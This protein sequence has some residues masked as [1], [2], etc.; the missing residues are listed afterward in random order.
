MTRRKTDL[1]SL[2][3]HWK[4]RGGRGSGRLP[5]DVKKKN[6]SKIVVVYKFSKILHPEAEVGANSMK[7]HARKYDGLDLCDHWID[8]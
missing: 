4:L 5:A 2:N 1:A 8:R 7:Y 3:V 6:S